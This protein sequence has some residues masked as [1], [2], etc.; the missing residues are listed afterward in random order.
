MCIT[1]LSWHQGDQNVQVLMPGIRQWAHTV[2]AKPHRG[3]SSYIGGL[4]QVAL[5]R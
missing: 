2:C 3:Y 4:V 1:L 5:S